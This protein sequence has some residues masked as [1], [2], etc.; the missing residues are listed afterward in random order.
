MP[1]IDLSGLITAEDKLE[2]RKQAARDKRTRLIADSDWTQLPDSPLQ[3]DTEWLDYRQAL[4][5]VPQQPG[6]PD[7]ISWPEEPA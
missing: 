6:F 7:I 2:Q 1:T 3:G 5:D 4:R